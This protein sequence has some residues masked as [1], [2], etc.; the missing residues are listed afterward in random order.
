MNRI[1]ELSNRYCEGDLTIDEIQE[2]EALLIESK[3]A[4]DIYRNV[5]ATDA[6][7]VDLTDAIGVDSNVLETPEAS[8]RKIRPLPMLA[9]GA[10]AAAV[11]VMLTLSLSQP[12]KQNTITSSTKGD[13][14]LVPQ[15][16]EELK[17]TSI[18]VI[19]KSFHTQGGSQSLDS[20]S[21]AHP[22]DLSFEEGIVQIEF[23][24]GV[25]MIVE[26]PAKL[27]LVDSM[28]VSCQTRKLNV[29]VP[30]VAHGFSVVSKD[31]NVKDVGTAFT[32]EC[33]PEGSSVTVTDG[34]VELYNN[35][36][37]IETLEQDQARRWT[38]K[39]TI[40]KTSASTEMVTSK[41]IDSYAH[42]HDLKAFKRWQRHMEAL[43]LREDLIILYDFQNTDSWQR[44]LANQDNP[45][46]SN[47]AIVGAKWTN[48]RFGNKQA[49]K[50]RGVHDRVR[51]NIPGEYRSMTM[52][53]WVRIDSLDQWLSSLLLTD[54]FAPGA[55][56]WQISDIGELII[57]MRAQK[58]MQNLFS[59]EILGPK[60]FGQWIYVAMTY[61]SDAKLVTHF[62]NGKRVASAEI[63]HPHLIR[64]GMSEVGNWHCNG[65]KVPIRGFNGA[66]DEMAIFSS[67]LP[68]ETILNHYQQ[69][70]P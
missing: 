10:A 21:T 12:G 4:R 30:D 37:L 17:S 35:D 7:L 24:S 64:L 19:T 36:D 23:T 67:A 20:G 5:V 56:H 44:K 29:E 2:L 70:R 31:V 69:G 15:A 1:E 46:A 43:K 53:A 11:A 13:D 33:D 68:A 3:E 52:S 51:V 55:L 42:D 16:L 48:G 18:G 62:L 57:G 34:S 45:S 8:E 38:G 54:G 28:K 49:L 6:S 60:D 26:G 58:D 59:E 47:G 63:E 65:A 27:E 32:M 25:V 66:I 50:F 39:D 22:G 41:T 9:I 14:T 61:D 40:V